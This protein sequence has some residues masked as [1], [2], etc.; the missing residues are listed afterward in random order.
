M[1]DV[2]SDGPGDRDD[3]R[4]VGWFGDLLWPRATVKVPSPHPLHPRPYNDYEGID[5]EGR[6]GLGWHRANGTT[7]NS[8]AET[9]SPMAQGDRKVPSLHPLHP[10][11][12]NDYD[13]GD[14]VGRGG[15][16]G[17]WGNGV[18]FCRDKGRGGVDAGALCLSLWQCDSHGF[19]EAGWSYPNEDKHKAP[20]STQP[21]PLSL[22]DA[23]DA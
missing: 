2:I 10:R 5:G 13:G 3:S 7:L 6:G 16:M 9:R 21:F 17:Q 14:S 4:L 12:Y 8:W 11:P 1:G 23:G 18:V 15:L 19:R 22:Q 20:A